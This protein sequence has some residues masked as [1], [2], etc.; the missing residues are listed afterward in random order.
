MGE[1]GISTLVGLEERDGGGRER[2]AD[3]RR[4][5]GVMLV[6]QESWTFRTNAFRQFCRECLDCAARGAHGKNEKNGR[7]QDDS[8]CESS[9]TKSD[10]RTQTA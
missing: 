5:D 4:D 7:G 8:S 1:G 6:I 3:V 9:F 10:M 2:R